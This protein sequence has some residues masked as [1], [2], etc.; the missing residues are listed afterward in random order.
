[1]TYHICDISGYHISSQCYDSQDMKCDICNQAEKLSIVFKGLFEDKWKMLK[2]K[3][4]LFYNVHSYEQL[5]IFSVLESVD[6]K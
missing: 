3:S 5:I 1:M 4:A 2:T 6:F